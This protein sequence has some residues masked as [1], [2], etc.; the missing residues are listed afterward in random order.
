MHE[1]RR[2]RWVAGTAPIGQMARGGGPE[3]VAPCDRQAERATWYTRKLSSL[4]LPIRSCSPFVSSAQRPDGRGR[5][6]PW[7]LLA[8]RVIFL[9]WSNGTLRQGPQR[10][11]RTMPSRL[12]VSWHVES[13]ATS[14][15][16]RTTLMHTSATMRIFFMSFLPSGT[17]RGPGYRLR[18]PRTHAGQTL[19]VRLDRA[20][21][22]KTAC[23]ER[24]R[25]RRPISPGGSV[26]RS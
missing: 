25:D 4:S 1:G 18:V 23:I 2:R 6:L 17:G 12:T 10:G 19:P 13:L 16:M 3:E 5:P 11:H 21:L 14:A 24:R 15:A 8:P 9:I 22:A 26:A 7:L 20:L